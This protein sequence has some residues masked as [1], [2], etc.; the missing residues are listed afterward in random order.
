MCFLCVWDSRDDTTNHYR[1]AKT[2][3]PP[4]EE[5]AIG[6]YSVRHIPFMDPQKVY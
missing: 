2:I 3:W 1:H 4:R 5:L 6:K